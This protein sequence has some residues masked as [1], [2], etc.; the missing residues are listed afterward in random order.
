MPLD[1]GAPDSTSW[2]AER[3]HDGQVSEIRLLVRSI[4]DFDRR[5]YRPN[6][7]SLDSSFGRR[8][9]RPNDFRLTE[10]RAQRLFVDGL[11]VTRIWAEPPLLVTRG[12]LEHQP[13][14]LIAIREIVFGPRDGVD[15]LRENA[16]H[17]P[18]LAVLVNEFSD[19]HSSGSHAGDSCVSRCES[20][21]QRT[22]SGAASTRDIDHKSKAADCDVET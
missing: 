1:G 21:T 4:I 7:F 9:A 19:C 16:P 2:V 5:R 3:P 10:H 6:D 20:T 11:P 22:C 8:S 14:E 13:A 12:S 18:G 15:R 17:S